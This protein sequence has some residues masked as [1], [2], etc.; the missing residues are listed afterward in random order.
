[1]RCEGC[2]V[3]HHPG[4]WVTNGGCSTE[5]EHRTTPIAQA[6]SAARPIGSEA[7]HPGEGLRVGT[8]PQRS[9]GD[10]RA[11][12][13]RADAGGAN[14]EGGGRSREPVIGAPD[15]PEEGWVIGEEAAPRPVRRAPPQEPFVPPTPPRRYVPP[16]GDVPG[17]P[18]PL[19]KIYSGNPITRYWYVPVAVVLAVLVAFGVIWAADQ[20]RGGDS[21]NLAAGE[22]TSTA[23]SGETPTQAPATASAAA[24]GAT[25]VSPGV[26]AGKFQPNDVVVVTGAGADD[27][28]NVRVAP[29]TGNDA[30]VCLKDGQEV[31]V[32]GGP[33]SAGDLQWWKVKTELGEGWAA[34]DYLV[35]KP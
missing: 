26:G 13:D 20:F 18:R 6:Y 33:Q 7:P 27:C 9:T 17:G 10:R 32:T 34:E 24:A 22:R 3:M 1:M 35:K 30:I 23:Q 4:C 19:P 14:R 8:R 2:G 29:G 16:T 11:V 15:S 21:S 12:R 25:T 31:T 5:S 28:L